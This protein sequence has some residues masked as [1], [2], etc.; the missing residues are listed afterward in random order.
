MNEIFSYIL[1]IILG[2]FLLGLLFY[3]FFIVLISKDENYKPKIKGSDV[4]INKLNHSSPNRRE[5]PNN[6]SGRKEGPGEHR[7]KHRKAA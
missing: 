7:K 6:P 5:V 2:G 1:V 4:P 3:S